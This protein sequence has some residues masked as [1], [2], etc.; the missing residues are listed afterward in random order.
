MLIKPTQ[1]GRSYLLRN[2]KFRPTANHFTSSTSFCLFFSGCCYQFP[3]YFFLFLLY[4]LSS[5]H[6]FWIS[7][8]CLSY[9]HIPI[10]YLTFIFSLRLRPIQAQCYW[11][12]PLRYYLK[13]NVFKIKCHLYHQTFTTFLS[14]KTKH[15]QWIDFTPHFH[16]Y[17]QSRVDPLGFLRVLGPHAFSCLPAFVILFTLVLSILA[18]SCPTLYLSE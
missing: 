5:H 13:F 4:P 18:H 2:L 6:I 15:H 12:S 1:I 9:F 16:T 10:L 17:L 3:A 8:S 14:Q 7:S 11:I